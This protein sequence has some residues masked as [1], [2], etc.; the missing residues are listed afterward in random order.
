MVSP[1]SL[2]IFA[3]PSE[4]SKRTPDRDSATNI[5]AVDGLL[6]VKEIGSGITLAD[7]RRHHSL[8][9]GTVYSKLEV[10]RQSGDL[11]ISRVQG[12]TSTT[13]EASTK[14]IHTS[15][16]VNHERHLLSKRRV[17]HY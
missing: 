11:L 12:H 8:T 16:E 3:V 15:C 6:A 7:K 2:K 4:P 14:L 9:A 1:A 17:S 13:T 5:A 10:K